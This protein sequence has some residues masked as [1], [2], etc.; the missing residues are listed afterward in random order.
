MN[1]LWV[2]N[3]RAK[4]L[5]DSNLLASTMF[6][7]RIWAWHGITEAGTL[8]KK[9]ACFRIHL[10]ELGIFADPWLPSNLDFRP[11]FQP[12][13]TINMQIKDLWWTN[14]KS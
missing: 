5:Y 4:Y 1:K 11:T 6:K 10:G 8:L 14:I 9:G 13:I 12:H 7:S 2:Q 3:Y